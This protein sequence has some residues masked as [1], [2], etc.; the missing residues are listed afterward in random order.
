MI[1]IRPWNIGLR[2]QAPET[3]TVVPSRR[4]AN[5]G[6]STRSSSRVRSACI[7]KRPLSWRR[8]KHSGHDPLTPMANGAG[9]A[10]AGVVRGAGWWGQWAEPASLSKTE[11]NTKFGLD[12][13]KKKDRWLKGV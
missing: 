9:G 4:R 11:P 10:V 6:C 7:H 1:F 3:K 13:A 2:Q 12:E 5:T 8:G